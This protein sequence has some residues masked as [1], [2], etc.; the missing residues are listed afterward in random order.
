MSLLL[1][2]VEGAVVQITAKKRIQGTD[3]EN[4]ALKSKRGGARVSKV[5]PQI[6]PSFSNYL[7][8]RHV[9]MSSIVAEVWEV[10]VVCEI[11]VDLQG[12]DTESFALK[13]K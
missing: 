12:I 6:I 11:G 1:L 4:F 13:S 9:P 7:T 8:V 3:A 5:S 2:V 10:K